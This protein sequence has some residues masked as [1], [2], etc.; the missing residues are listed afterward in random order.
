MVHGNV[1]ATP[2]PLLLFP[3][4]ASVPMNGLLMSIF[5]T[6]WYKFLFGVKNS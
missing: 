3:E 4:M 2:L 1:I 5:G 6:Q